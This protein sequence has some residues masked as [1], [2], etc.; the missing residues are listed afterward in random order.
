MASLR[1]AAGRVCLH[2]VRSTWPATYESGSGTRRPTGSTRYILGGAWTD[3]AYSFQHPELRSPFDR[4]DQNGFRLAEYLD[5][6]P[7]HDGADRTDSTPCTRL[8]ER[9]AC[10]RRRLSRTT[11]TSL[12]SIPSRSI[13]KSNR[14]TR[15][16]RAGPEKRS[17]SLPPTM[18]NGCPR[19]CSS[20]R[21]VRPPYQAVVYFPGR[22][23]GGR[24]N[25][26]D[27]SR[28]TCSIS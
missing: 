25:E 19:T 24:A 26:R 3:P 10:I 17:A 7:L 22:R 11:R 5:S 14:S 12:A 28:S 1:S 2:S 9:A 8:Y 13:R 20:R 4:S 15:A 6:Q 27:R 23:C 18:A 21:N 16:Q